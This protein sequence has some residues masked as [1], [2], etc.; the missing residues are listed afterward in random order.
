MQRGRHL[1]ASGLDCRIR[2]WIVEH[3][4][5]KVRLAARV[6]HSFETVA[7]EREHHADREGTAIE[8]KVSDPFQ[9]N[10]LVEHP[11]RPPASNR[12]VVV[13]N[14]FDLKDIN[15]CH[16]F[17]KVSFIVVGESPQ[18]F[19]RIRSFFPNK[20]AGHAIITS[21]CQ[22]VSD[23]MASRVETCT[24]DDQDPSLGLAKELMDKL[25]GA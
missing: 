22:L 16:E 5:V 7:S 25:L 24:T 17:P 1:A 6:F 8:D 3:K 11:C 13:P 18:R 15:M 12:R 20:Q 2:S 4:N 21:S 10:F 23:E 19:W 14:D 9:V